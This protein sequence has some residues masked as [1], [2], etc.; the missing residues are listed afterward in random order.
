VFPHNEHEIPA[1]RQLAAELGVDELSL[2][3]ASGRVWSESGGL[4]LPP[5]PARPGGLLCSDPWKYFAVDWDGAAHLCCRAF[6]ARHVIGDMNDATLR[7]I[8][9]GPR[10][11]AA[12][13]I[14]RDGVWSPADGP[15]PCTG[16]IRVRNFV[17][18]IA[19]LGHTL[20][21][22]LDPAKP[23]IRGRPTKGP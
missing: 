17:P 18:E 11:Q 8:F 1:A 23:E 4:Q 12:R 10:M 19:A 14:I 21:L 7:E 6:Q 22:E 2:E 16:C 5:A 20:S 13:R 3:G 9:D 15:L